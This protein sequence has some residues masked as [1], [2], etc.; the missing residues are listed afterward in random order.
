[1]TFEEL[2]LD[3]VHDA[4]AIQIKNVM[5]LIG[6]FIEKNTT[7]EDKVILLKAIYGIV[8]NGHYDHD[9]AAKQ[10]ENM[11]YVEGG[12]KYYAPYWSD[13]EIKAV[14]ESIKD[15]I[16]PYNFYDFEVVMNMVKSDQYLKL[17]KWFPTETD[18]E[19]FDRYVDEAVNW[20]VDA[21]NPFGDTKVW[22]YFNH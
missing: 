21:D 19:L 11:Y 13:G 2:I 20:L 17:K 4:D 22:S 5:S 15:S 12:I 9:F 6:D 1:M 8:G 14:Y 16:K 18:E 7:S 3:Y 10:I